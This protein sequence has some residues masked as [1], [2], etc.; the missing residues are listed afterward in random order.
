MRNPETARRLS[1]AMAKKN[2][3]AKELSEKSGVSEPS[4][5]QYL[6]GVFAPKN[7]SAGKMAKALDCDP[8]WLM[9]FEIDDDGGESLVRKLKQ[10]KVIMADATNYDFMFGMNDISKKM[11]L[12]E[13]KSVLA[14]ATFMQ[15]QKT[16]DK[17]DDE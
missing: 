16:D 14:F 1:E 17:K 15:S 2:M 7:I 13:Q 6:H 12:E 4:I 9:G 5:S 8:L 3:T 10:E 11:T